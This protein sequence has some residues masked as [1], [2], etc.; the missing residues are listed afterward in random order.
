MTKVN[1]ETQ[2]SVR[3]V[4][5]TQLY[6]QFKERCGDH[7]DMSRVIRYLLT[8]WIKAKGSIRQTYYSDADLAACAPQESDPNDNIE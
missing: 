2:K 5:P 8:E 7:G 3:V 6:N 1:K 4:L